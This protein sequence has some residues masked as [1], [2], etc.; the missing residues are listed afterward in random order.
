MTDVAELGDDSSI[1]PSE[2]LYLRVHPDHVVPDHDSPGEYRPDSGSF[3]RDESLSVDL[4]S[5]CTP[6]QTQDRAGGVPFHVASF[7]VRDARGEGC[8][9]R[10]EP[11][12]E[13]DAHALVI[14]D[15]ANGKG[16]LKKIQAKNISK[17]TQIILWHPHF[18]KEVYDRKFASVAGTPPNQVS[19]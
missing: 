2:I 16:S 4:A 17:K 9:V 6:E 5:M 12:P 11:L 7:S 15:N 19:D 14:G 18:P 13:N 1:E 3:R 10:R 8:R